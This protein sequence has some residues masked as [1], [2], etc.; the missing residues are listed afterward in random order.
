VIYRTAPDAGHIVGVDIGR[1]V[2]HVAMA[3]LDGTIVAR[4]EEPN[5]SRSGT[6]LLRTVE[7]T[8]HLAVAQAGLGDEDIVVTALG[9]PGIPDAASATVH[10]APN[11]PG[12][13]R[14]GLLHAPASALAAHGSEVIVENDANLCAVGEHAQ[15]AA[16]GVEVVA[17][18][19]VGTGYR[20][21]NLGRRQALSRC[22]RCSR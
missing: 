15:G 7:E 13:E 14:R 12:W 17:C 22:A 20:H 2:L 5:R 18:L 3:D 4:L 1:R 6:A 19:T 11:L 16:Q 9:T 10:R 21:G 8:I